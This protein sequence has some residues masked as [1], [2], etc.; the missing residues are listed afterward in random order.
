MERITDIK[1]LRIGDK[2]VEVSNFTD[3]E[4]IDMEV[5]AIFANCDIYCDFDNNEGDIWEYNINHDKIYKL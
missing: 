5:V 3:K 1:D 2:I 4:S